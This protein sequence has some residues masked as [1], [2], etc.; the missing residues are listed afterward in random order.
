MTKNPVLR[1]M[2]A[3]LLGLLKQ[4]MSRAGVQ[5]GQHAVVCSYDPTCPKAYHHGWY[6]IITP[7]GG[8]PLGASIDVLQ[9]LLP[10]D[11]AK[12]REATELFTSGVRGLVSGEVALENDA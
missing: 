2:V 10:L 3:E 8:E 6:A 1:R 5:P 11:D 12:L 7:A 9:S 4:K